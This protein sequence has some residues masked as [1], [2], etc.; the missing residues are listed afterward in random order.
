MFS[1]WRPEHTGRNVE[2]PL[3][4]VLFRTPTHCET[5]YMVSPQIFPILIHQPCKA[6]SLIWM[7][8][9]H[10]HTWMLL[11]VSRSTF[12]A[13]WNSVIYSGKIGWNISFELGLH[14]NLM[15]VWYSWCT[16][17][18]KQT[19]ITQCPYMYMYMFMELLPRESNIRCLP[20]PQKIPKSHTNK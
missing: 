12:S 16:G 18:I 6:L 4:Q 1:W 8:L 15:L 13:A 3:T 10:S 7:K 5:L 20:W 9:S 17:I 14:W 2:L 19:S 11:I